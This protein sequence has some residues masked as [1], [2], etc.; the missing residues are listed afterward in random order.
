MKNLNFESYELIMKIYGLKAEDYELW[1]ELLE[2]YD[3]DLLDQA[4][5]TYCKTQSKTPKIADITKIV[6]DIIANKQ[7]E[8]Q[9]QQTKEQKEEALRQVYEEAQRADA[10]GYKIVYEKIPNGQYK[11]YWMDKDEVFRE[12]L[13]SFTRY[14]KSS[15]FE[16][17]I[18][19]K[20][21]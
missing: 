12:N 8:T 1:S 10:K 5:K 20:K 7:T 14:Y 19:N 2:D 15:P 21:I 17:F 13:Q 18:Q 11:Y 3:D 4:I 6:E 16:V 9:E